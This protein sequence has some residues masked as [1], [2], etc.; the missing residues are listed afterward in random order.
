MSMRSIRVVGAAFL[1]ASLVIAPLHARA[2]IVTTDAITAERGTIAEREKVVSFLERADA[3]RKLREYGVSARDAK[4]RV[5]ALS[6]KEVRELALQID[7]LPAGGNIG[8]FTDTQVIILLLLV[9]L[10]AV[11]VS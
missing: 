1:A 6:D 9:I 2:E 7:S 5:A 10:V 8:N 4:E 11:L 3:A